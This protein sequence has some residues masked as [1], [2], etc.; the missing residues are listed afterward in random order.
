MKTTQTPI[1]SG[2]FYNMLDFNYPRF[3]AQARAASLNRAAVRE[4]AE[5]GRGSCRIDCDLVGQ[6]AHLRDMFPF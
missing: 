6:A 1:S 3:T 5:G 4:F 2:E